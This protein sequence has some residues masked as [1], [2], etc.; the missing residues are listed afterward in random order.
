MDSHTR[1][2]SA[3]AGHN[4][5]QR[6]LPTELRVSSGQSCKA[7]PASP[8][9]QPLGSGRAAESVS[10]RRRRQGRGANE[11]RDAGQVGEGVGG[12]GPPGGFL[13]KDQGKKLAQQKAPE[14]RKGRCV[15][16]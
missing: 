12:R 8:W 4:T 15:C 10:Q 2:G 11:G 5:K 6:V 7:E 13:E 3:A 16:K 14:K 1:Q 9:P